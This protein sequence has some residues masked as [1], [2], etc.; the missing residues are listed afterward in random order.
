MSL[1]L[2][3]IAEYISSVKEIKLEEDTSRHIVQVLRMGKGKSIQLTNGKGVLLT[4]EII[5]DH[6]KHC[7]VS[8]K[9]TAVAM[10]SSRKVSIGISL[11]K[12][13]SRFEWF[14]EKATEIGVH[15]IVPLLCERTEKE[16]FRLDRL[17][18]VCISAMLQ[19]RQ[20]WLP[21]IHQPISFD[22]VFR[23]EE[24]ST[25]DQK[26]IAHCMDAENKTLI[27]GGN[28]MNSSAIILI[29]PEGDFTAA[30][31]DMAV[32]H[33]F[34]PVSLGRTRLRTETAGIVAATLLC[35]G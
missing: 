11:I 13:A 32:H 6:K 21:I 26:F 33:H 22:L 15:E 16:K 20:L 2:F 1:P 7:L 18:Q 14:V 24:I 17:T 12:N 29:G 28:K 3:Y 9:E 19:S 23:Q 25:I 5:D 27:A 34:Q 10:P 30:E 8:V 31:V 35:A 4:A